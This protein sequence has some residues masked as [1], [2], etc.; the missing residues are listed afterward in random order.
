MKDALTDVVAQ[1]VEFSAYPGHV[2]MAHSGMLRCAQWVVADL[3]GAL[4][5]ALGQFRGYEAV[6]VGHSLGAGV[7]TIGGLL[8]KGR[9]PGLR[10]YAFA[11]PCSL[12]LATATD[13]WCASHIT[14]VVNNRDVVCRLSIGSLDDLKSILCRLA[15]RN[16]ILQ[17]MFRWPLGSPDAAAEAD[18][19]WREDISLPDHG[20]PKLYMGGRLVHFVTSRRAWSL[21]SLQGL[22]APPTHTLF[23]RG[24]LHFDRICLH[25][26]FMHDHFPDQYEKVLGALVDKKRKHLEV[27]QNPI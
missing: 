23:E 13:P 24:Q 8:L 20:V 2:G 3:A 21:M 25:G 16:S 18:R 26:D 11:A 1:Y 10:V 17:R 14:S 6:L 4:E 22:F 12:D 19:A 9:I 5:L 27:T 15:E 7:A